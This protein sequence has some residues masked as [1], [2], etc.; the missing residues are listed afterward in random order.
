MAGRRS[1]HAGWRLPAP[2]PGQQSS[3]PQVGDS[4]RLDR[5]DVDRRAPIWR[6]FDVCC[7]H[8]Q[9]RWHHGRS[10]D[11]GEGDAST[12]NA[13]VFGDGLLIETLAAGSRRRTPTAPTSRPI[14][15]CRIGRSSGSIRKAGMS[16]RSRM[17]VSSSKTS[18]MGRSS[19]PLTTGVDFDLSSDHQV[20]VSTGTSIE[21]WDLNSGSLVTTFTPHRAMQSAVSPGSRTAAS[22]MSMAPPVSPL[23]RAERFQPKE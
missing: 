8:L 15:R 2:E 14:R 13:F 12:G 22:P 19:G 1:L 11:L 7:G 3:E 4:D 17:A 18:T 23:D 9:P 16:D 5:G 6:P 10:G 21:I 20:A